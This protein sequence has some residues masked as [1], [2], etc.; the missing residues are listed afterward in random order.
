MGP[1]P[2]EAH[3]A[4][5]GRVPPR[6]AAD[7]AVALFSLALLAL[8][9]NGDVL[10]LGSRAPHASGSYAAISVPAKSLVFW[11]LTLANYML[12]EAAIR[13]HS[14]THALRQLVHTLRLV[15]AAVRTAAGVG[16]RRRAGC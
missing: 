12:P 16:G 10:V 7:I 4:D 8:L 2:V 13:W 1:R 15:G 11:S 9:Q 3:P 5:V 14:G 6:L